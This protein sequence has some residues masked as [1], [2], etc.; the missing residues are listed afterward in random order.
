MILQG[1][2]KKRWDE[3]IKEWTG[4][5]YGRSTKAAENRTKS[6]EIVQIRLW[7]PENLQ[8]IIMG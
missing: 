4:M 6:K 8:G 2:L 7:C 3:N 5:D 1:T